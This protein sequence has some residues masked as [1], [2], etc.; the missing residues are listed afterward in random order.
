MAK[1][2]LP[3]TDT[4]C[5]EHDCESD[6]ENRQRPRVLRQIRHCID[7]PVFTGSEV[8]C[9]KSSD[10]Q[11]ERQ[12]EWNDGTV[13]HMEVFKGFRR[14]QLAPVFLLLDPVCIKT[15]DKRYL[16]KVV[17]RNRKRKGP[18]KRTSVTPR[19]SSDFF[20]LGNSNNDIDQQDEYCERP[21]ECAY[22]G[23]H[24]RGVIPLTIQV[25]EHAAWHPP[26]SKEVLDQEC[27]V[28][29]SN[30]QHE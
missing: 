24:I 20:I 13:W 11:A 10:E 23:Y 8:Q 29:T 14:H 25:S 4:H 15:A 5:D 6:N 18:L 2:I 22:G 21:H 26:K 27:H 16:S 19:V 30:K 28:E 12:Y 7:C 3:G 1:V 9:T 17:V